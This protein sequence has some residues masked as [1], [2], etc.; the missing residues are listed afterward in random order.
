ME[1]GIEN[2]A[3]SS[4]YYIGRVELFDGG[5]RIWHVRRRQGDGSGTVVVVVVFTVVFTV[6]FTF[7]F[8]Q[9][10]KAPPLRH[11]VDGG[12][13]VRNRQEISICDQH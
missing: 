4:S 8:V 9:T 6:L 10:D 13:A 2:R 7:V 1:F 5:R 11:Y 3:L 12:A